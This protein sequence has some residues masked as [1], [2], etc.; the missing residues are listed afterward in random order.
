MRGADFVMQINKGPAI[1]IICAGDGVS[2]S[3]AY[4]GQRW[5]AR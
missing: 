1:K 5:A 3:F 4:F 2:V